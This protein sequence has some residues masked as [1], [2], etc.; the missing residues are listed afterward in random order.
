MPSGVHGFLLAFHVQI[1]YA[2][3]HEIDDEPTAPGAHIQASQF[4]PVFNPGR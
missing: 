2:C 1:F 3:K 4:R